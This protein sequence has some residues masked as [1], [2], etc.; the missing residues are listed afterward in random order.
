MSPFFNAYQK[1]EYN[2]SDKKGRMML[3]NFSNY[4]KSMVI[5]LYERVIGTEHSFKI[6]YIKN[7]IKLKKKKRLFSMTTEEIINYF[8][9]KTFSERK[10]IYFY[11]VYLILS[12][13]EQTTTQF[14][15]LEQM[16]NGY[17]IS[18]NNKR[19]LYKLA[20][21]KI[22]FEKRVELTLK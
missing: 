22:D 16:R 4:E 12:L 18:Q 17:L 2:N 5:E 21:D 14:V 8:A 11:G 6:D 3:E 10:T 13:N 15:L 20:Y 19:E 7:M 9:F 1:S